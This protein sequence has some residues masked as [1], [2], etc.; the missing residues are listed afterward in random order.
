LM[1]ITMM[2][3]TWHHLQA[4]APKHEELAINVTYRLVINFLYIQ[5]IILQPTTHRLLC[6]R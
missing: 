4:S 3:A 1:T 6:A 2:M 5:N